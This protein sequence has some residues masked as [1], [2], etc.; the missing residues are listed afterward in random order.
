MI[1]LKPNKF[2]NDGKRDLLYLGDIKVTG[3]KPS[4]NQ[5]FSQFMYSISK[6]G[7][8]YI[9]FLDIYNDKISEKE[10]G[11]IEFSEEFPTC[12]RTLVIQELEPQRFEMLKKLYDNK[13]EKALEELN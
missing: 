10:N 1:N 12:T 6:N 7:K 8:V 13:L 3:G 4:V 2:Y 9:G 11:K 5:I